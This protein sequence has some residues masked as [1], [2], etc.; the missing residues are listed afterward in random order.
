MGARYGGSIAGKRVNRNRKKGTGREQRNQGPR[1]SFT[2]QLGRMIPTLPTNI[3]HAAREQP[4]VA[5]STQTTTAP[6]PVL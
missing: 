2:E 5:R 1:R 3:L 4:T 6:T